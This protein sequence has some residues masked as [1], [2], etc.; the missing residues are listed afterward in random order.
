MSIIEEL[1]FG[2]I[3]LNE[4]DLRNY[5][6]YQQAM[7]RVSQTRE[8]L[9]S[10]QPQEIQSAVDELLNAEMELLVEAERDAFRMGFRLAVQF[11]TAGL[12]PL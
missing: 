6:N 11:L 12:Q 3:R 1:W 7:Y 2:N 10:G 8:R 4:R 5:E 9:F